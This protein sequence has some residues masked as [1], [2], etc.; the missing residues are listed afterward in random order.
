[1][2]HCAL[3]QFNAGVSL[4][5]LMALLEHVSAEMSLRY[6]RLFDATVSAEYERALTLAKKRLGS[7]PAQPPPSHARYHH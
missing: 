3:Y 1:L 2:E 5:S 4:Q 7:L 6:G